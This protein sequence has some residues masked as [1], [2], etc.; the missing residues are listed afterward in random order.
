MGQY[1]GTNGRLT[2]ANHPGK[3]KILPPPFAVITWFFTS[4]HEKPQC[5]TP[6]AC[7]AAWVFNGM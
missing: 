3:M 2:G 5:K 7:T 4:K 1:G 6:F